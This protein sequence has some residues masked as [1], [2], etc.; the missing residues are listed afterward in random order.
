MMREDQTGAELK[1]HA[2]KFIDI[3][4][5]IDAPPNAVELVTDDRRYKVRINGIWT[6]REN[7]RIHTPAEIAEEL[8]LYNPVM[9][10]VR[11]LGPPRW[12]KAEVDLREQDYSS[13][14]LEFQTEDDA[15]TLLAA[16]RVAAYARFCEIVQHADKPPVLQ[17]SNCWGIGHHA[18]RCHSPT[19]CRICAEDHAE[20]DHPPATEQRQTFKRANCGDEHP[21]TDRRCPERARAAGTSKETKNTAVGGGTTRA[22]RKKTTKPRTSPET[23]TTTSTGDARRGE[24]L[25]VSHTAP[26]ES[27]SR[28]V[29]GDQDE[30]DTREDGGDRLGD[31]P[32]LE[33]EWGA[34]QPR[35]R[36]TKVKKNTD[37]TRGAANRY[38][39]L[40][41]DS[42]DAQAIAGDSLR[43]PIIGNVPQ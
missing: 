3:L 21:A 14:V 40:E 6:G 41:D 35:K 20:K 27:G 22:P 16:K 11:P 18:G 34:V 10:K 31:G 25:T 29:G 8:T 17:C 39:G 33:T 38:A 2:D 32:G 15:N 28:D 36:R 13:V 9:D 5:P 26:G 37:D 4:A 30:M 24:T 7:G 19:K 43:A 1:A 12:M 23:S 42:G